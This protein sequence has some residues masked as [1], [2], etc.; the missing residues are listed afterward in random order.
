MWAVPDAARIQVRV[1]PGARRPGIVGRHGEGWRVRVAAPAQDGRANSELRGRL[2]EALRVR[3]AQVTI[4]AGAG[5]RDKVIA[6]E[7]L[8]TA[9]VERRLDA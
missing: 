3:P 8:T 6:I 1:S 9:E 7:G 2:A 4:V 5:G